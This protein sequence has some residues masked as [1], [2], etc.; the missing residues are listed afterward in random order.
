MG[1]IGHPDDINDRILESPKAKSYVP[2]LTKK[3]KKSAN[4][5]SENV[6]GSQEAR[7]PTLTSNR[8]SVKSR[9]IDHEMAA[10]VLEMN[11]FMGD[12]LSLPA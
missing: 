11:E 5:S 9:G 10:A 4:G 3:I 2:L 6:T 12:R 8:Q 1:Y 7:N